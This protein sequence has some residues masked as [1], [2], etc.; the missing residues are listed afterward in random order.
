MVSHTK[1]LKSTLK[2]F[3]DDQHNFRYSNTMEYTVSTQI[4]WEVVYITITHYDY[5][6]Q[7]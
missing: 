7:K 1:I 3:I 2:K 4:V 6:A 5:D